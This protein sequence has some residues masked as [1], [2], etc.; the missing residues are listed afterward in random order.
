MPAQTIF[1]MSIRFL[2]DHLLKSIHE[3]VMGMEDDLIRW[4]VTVPAIW[5]NGAKQFM[6]EAAQNVRIFL[7][8]KI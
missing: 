8:I 1:T 3:K 4:V 2:K 5:D 6:R 7:S